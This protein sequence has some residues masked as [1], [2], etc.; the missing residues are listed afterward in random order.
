MTAP[1]PASGSTQP[2]G[3]PDQRS[4]GRRPRSRWPAV[5]LGIAAVA[6]LTGGLL[7]AFAPSLAVF[8][9]LPPAGV[10]VSA[11]LPAARVVAWGAAAAGVG[12]LLLAAV[13]VPG[14][15][16]DVVSPAGYAGLRAARW[17]ALV[18]AVASTVVAVLTVAENGVLPAGGL[19]QSGPAL[20]LGLEQIQPATG[21]LLSALVALLV[22]GLAGWV[23][24]WRGAVGLVLLAVGALLPITLTAA[25]NAERSHD[26]AGDALTLHVLGAVLWLGSAL[27]T[28]GHLARRGERP[29]V[30]LRRHAA[31]STWSLLLV[32]ASGLISSAYAVAPADLLTSG[33][34][35]VVLLSAAVLAVLAV[36]GNRL[37]ALAGPALAGRSGGS[38]ASVG[39][40]TMEVVLLG[41]AAALSTGLARLVPPAELGYETSRS[42]YLIGFDLPAELHP[43]DLLL[44]CRLD[45][46]FGPLAVL[47]AGLYLVGLRRLNRNSEPWPRRYSAAWF[48]GC[49]VLLVATSSGL[50]SY[51]P[52]M[53]SVHMVQHMLLATLVPALLVL[54]HGA[55][56]ARRVAAP[57]TERRLASLLGSPAT[58]LASHPVLA[59]AAV[60]ATLFGL[61]PT[62]L[63]AAVLQEH[64][65]H[66]AM[67]VAFFG[68]GLALFWSILGKGLGR[69]ALPPIGQL[70]M[71]FAVMALHAGFAAWLLG[72]P[73]PVAAAFYGS[74]RLPFVPDLLA[75]QRLGAILGW[76]LGELPVILAVLALVLRWSRD[77]RPVSPAGTPAAASPGTPP[78]PPSGPPWRTWR[79]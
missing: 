56:L 48:A 6:A 77:D 19:W 10:L 24:S 55:T 62:G 26:I 76:A 27:A 53:F 60:A 37:R 74:L 64:W 65:A 67:N 7:S 61:Y 8:Y 73:V 22:A 5:G 23:L 16:D 49:A 34:G 13:L 9:G 63:Y 33:F 38:A 50:G 18:Q 3:G 79:G 28:A 45:L 20:V 32:G 75:D 39:L 59:W 78:S 2:A 54:G 36:V 21:W 66:L 1:A 25:T 58:T 35:R 52:A 42:I 71:I 29:A 4:S 43:V 44:R 51:A 31:I 14:R 40:L 15:P 69:R 17:C 11:G 72:Q 68:T 57:G 41:A 47:G 46:V 30:V 12:Q 70:V